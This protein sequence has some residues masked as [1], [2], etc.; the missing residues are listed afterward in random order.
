MTVCRLFKD[1][2]RV[3][4]KSFDQLEDFDQVCSVPTHLQ[5]P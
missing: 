2:E 1:V 5:G 4:D 3:V